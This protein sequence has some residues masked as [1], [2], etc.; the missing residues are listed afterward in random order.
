MGIIAQI[1]LL[2]F[3]KKRNKNLKK[4]IVFLENSGTIESNGVKDS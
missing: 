4:V 1:I 2:F 3:V